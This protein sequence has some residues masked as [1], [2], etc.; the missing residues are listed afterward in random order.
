MI[1][2]GEIY[3]TLDGLS[4][5]SV[6]LRQSCRLEALI[7]HVCTFVVQLLALLLALYLLRFPRPTDGDMKSWFG[8]CV[9]LQQG[10]LRLFSFRP[11]V[12]AGRQW[13]ARIHDTRVPADLRASSLSLRPQ[14]PRYVITLDSGT[15]WSMPRDLQNS[16]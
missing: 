8:F 6:V 7:I 13:R 4:K 14:R 15:K 2:T 5:V 3:R 12:R 9:S 16:L 10:N 1:R 11:S